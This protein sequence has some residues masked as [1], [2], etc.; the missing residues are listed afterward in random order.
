M[1][2]IWGAKPSPDPTHPTRSTTIA[3]DS[4]S[5]SVAEQF[6]QFVAARLQLC[7]LRPECGESVLQEHWVEGV[8]LERGEITVD[9]G[10]GAGD[11][12]LHAGQF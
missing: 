7:R 5:W 4:G 9:R 3:G 6:G 1:G 12:L 8:A 10:A 11:F 2:Q